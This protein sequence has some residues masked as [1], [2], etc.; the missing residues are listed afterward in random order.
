LYDEF[1]RFRFHLLLWYI[2]K[3]Q[4]SVRISTFDAFPYHVVKLGHNNML[5]LLLQ[6]WTRLECRGLS[7]WP[8]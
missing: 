4:F 3:I 8:E 5:R 6:V 7:T 2:Q 1:K